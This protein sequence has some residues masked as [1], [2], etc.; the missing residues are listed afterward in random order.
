LRIRRFPVP[1][2]SF[3]VLHDVFRTSRLIHL[4]GTKAALD[5]ITAGIART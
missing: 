1:V 5:I 4:I 3:F 2:D